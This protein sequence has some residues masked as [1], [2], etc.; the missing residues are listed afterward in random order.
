MKII[1]YIILVTIISTIYGQ[2]ENIFPVTIN[3]KFPDVTFQTAYGEDLK[4]TDFN[5][6]NVMLV[7]QRGKVTPT[8]WCPI[9]HYQYLEYPE[10]QNTYAG[11]IAPNCPGAVQRRHPPNPAHK[12]LTPFADRNRHPNRAGGNIHLSSTQI[13]AC[14]SRNLSLKPAACLTPEPKD[15]GLKKRL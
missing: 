7:F 14:L 15:R 2:N 10:M 9:C 13:V 3:E 6:K 12:A 1:Q 5:G 4:I 11:L 8:V